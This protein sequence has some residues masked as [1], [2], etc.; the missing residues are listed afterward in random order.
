M[1]LQVR[2]PSHFANSLESSH[3]IFMSRFCTISCSN[4]PLVSSHPIGEAITVPFTLTTLQDATSGTLIDVYAFVRRP[5]VGIIRHPSSHG[6]GGEFGRLHGSQLISNEGMKT[7][8][9]IRVKGLR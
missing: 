8:P 2:A 7:L 9:S 6:A 4:I 3:M 1:L 5:L